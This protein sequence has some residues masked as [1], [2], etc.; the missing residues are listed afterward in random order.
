MHSRLFDIV[1]ERLDKISSISK[2]LQ[3]IAQ[4]RQNLPKTARKSQKNGLNIQYVCH[5]YQTRGLHVFIAILHVQV[6]GTGHW[7][8]TGWANF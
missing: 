7:V 2:I 6:L 3:I 8:K 1:T 5:K 4:N